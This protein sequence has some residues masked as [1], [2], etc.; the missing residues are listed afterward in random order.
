MRLCQLCTLSNKINHLPWIS[1]QRLKR[2]S[3]LSCQFYHFRWISWSRGVIPYPTWGRF[4]LSA[5]QCRMASRQPRSVSCSAIWWYILLFR[6]WERTR[7]SPFPRDRCTFWRVS[8]LRGRLFL[9]SSCHRRRWLRSCGSFV[10]M[11]S[12]RCAGVLAL[13]FTFVLLLFECYY[14]WICF[15]INERSYISTCIDDSNI[16]L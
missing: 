10:S 9:V 3:A 11:R 1:V 15:V 4:W 7:Q 14:F 13:L 16:L 8:C 6:Y 5:T 2:L 12:R